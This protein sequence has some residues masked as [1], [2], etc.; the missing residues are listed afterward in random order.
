MIKMIE[1]EI[2]I[3]K[4]IKFNFKENE[5]KILLKRKKE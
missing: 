5:N 1:N 2:V 4:I 3:R